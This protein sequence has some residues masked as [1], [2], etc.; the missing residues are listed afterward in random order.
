MGTRNNFEPTS[1]HLLEEDFSNFRLFGIGAETEK[2]KRNKRFRK[3]KRTER[4]DKRRA[5]REE[6]KTHTNAE[7][8]ENIAMKVP[9]APVRAG[10]LA[11]LRLNIFGLSRKLYP[12]LL[13]LEEAKKKNIDLANREKAIEKLKK[14]KHFYFQL[15]GRS[16]SIDTML[17]KGF[18]KPIFN[19]KKV[20]A[21]HKKQAQNIV[22]SFDGMLSQVFLV[23][24]VVD[25]FNNSEPT[26]IDF[27]AFE[28]KNITDNNFSNEYDLNDVFSDVAGYDDAA[29]VISGLTPLATASGIASGLGGGA[30]AAGGVSAATVASI[31][32]AGLGVV[33]AVADAAKKSKDTKAAVSD[34][35][36]AVGS[37][38]YKKAQEDIEKAKNE[39][40][41]KPPPIDKAELDRIMKSAEAENK[42]WG[43]PKGV[44]Y[45][46]F[47]VGGALLI[48]GGYKLV[49][50]LKAPKV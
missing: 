30:A 5:A 50:H 38:E 43:M 44:A 49:K 16:I 39:G 35:P 15:G 21:E 23:K 14:I 17:K 12:A 8:A 22:S 29:E 24:P 28:D 40:Y 20:K 2:Q 18:N 7:R 42:I 6:R 46:V 31:A 19:T 26:T 36:Y 11:G 10:F 9:M 13:T 4:F 33:G 34:N 32:S 37:P 27:T 3:N 1:S 47:A 41:L 25:P 48:F 45:G